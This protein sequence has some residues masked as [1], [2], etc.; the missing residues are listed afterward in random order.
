AGWPISPPAVLSALAVSLVVPGVLASAGWLDRYEPPPAPLL[1]VLA[2]MT[3]TVTL[4][5]TSFGSRLIADVPLAGLIG[6]QSFRLP[7]EWWLHRIYVE[8]IIPV[9]L[10]YEG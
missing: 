6:F 5:F 7:L 10:T 4:A 3:V 1:M 8:G 9:Q 2:V